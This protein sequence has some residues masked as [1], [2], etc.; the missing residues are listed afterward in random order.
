VRRPPPGMMFYID[1]R[2]RRTW[3]STRGHFGLS[4]TMDS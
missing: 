4:H 2:P 3:S 1:Y